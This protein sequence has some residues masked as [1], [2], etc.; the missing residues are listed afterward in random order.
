LLELEPGAL[1]SKRTYEIS[2]IFHSIDRTAVNIDVI[3]EH[4]RPG[5][6]GSMWA[7]HRTL[8]SMPMQLENGM[9]ARLVFRPTHPERAYKIFLKGLNDSEARFAVDHVLLRP[10][11]VNAWRTGTWDGTATVFWNN[12]PVGKAG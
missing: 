8:R 5:G 9:I 7:E 2:F 3:V 11:D 4:E 1:D 6:G 12:I 10:L